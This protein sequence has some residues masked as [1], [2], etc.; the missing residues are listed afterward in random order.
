[1]LYK[2]PLES[3]ID[4]WSIVHIIVF[5]K[6][7]QHECIQLGYLHLSPFVYLKLKLY[8]QRKV[9]NQSDNLTIDPLTTKTWETWVKWPLM[10]ICDTTF[11]RSWWKLQDSVHG[12]MLKKKLFLGNYEIS[13]IWDTMC[14]N[15]EIPFWNSWEF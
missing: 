6:W 1:M 4:L 14:P 5:Y 11:K 13:K 3:L 7:M 8:D 10:E 15:F 12:H 2:S 9:W